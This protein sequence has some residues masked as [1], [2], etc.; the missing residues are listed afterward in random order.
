MDGCVLKLGTTTLVWFKG[1]FFFFTIIF[2]YTGT[3]E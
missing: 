3:N 1:E 2:V